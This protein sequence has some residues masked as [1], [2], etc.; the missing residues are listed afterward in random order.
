MVTNTTMRARLVSVPV[1][2]ASIPAL[3]DT[4][5]RSHRDRRPLAIGWAATTWRG[6]RARRPGK[7][8]R[9]RVSA[10]V[11]VRS[12]PRTPP[13]APP[14]C[15]PCRR[16][17]RRV[18]RGL[19]FATIAADRC[20]SG[21]SPGCST[22]PRAWSSA[23][24]LVLLVPTSRELPRRVLLA[25]CLLLGWSQ[26]LWWWPLAVGEPGR[27]T[28]GLAVLAGALAAWVGAA[29]HPGAR[30]RRLRPRLRPADVALG[31]PVGIGIACTG[32]V[33]RGRRPRPRPW[34]CSWAAG[35]TSPTS[36]WST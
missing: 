32:A 31:L 28:L 26:V 6:R 2:R 19:V 20:C 14:R 17:P 21:D 23:T 13:Q 3:R 1:T 18:V 22:A 34:A 4:A 7:R 5:V 35:T 36:A 30:A 24:V 11:E 27:V 10:S 15:A 25:G 8:A 12:S 29:E 33:A 16:W 9:A